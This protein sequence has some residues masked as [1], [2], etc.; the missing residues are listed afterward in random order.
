M[1]TR[2]RTLTPINYPKYPPELEL[3]EYEDSEEDVFCDAPTA[4]S[5]PVG[6]KPHLIN[7]IISKRSLELIR[8][9]MKMWLN[10]LKR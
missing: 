9:E 7:S 1:I 6:Y 2:A 4:S 5:L 10:M 3:H 8:D